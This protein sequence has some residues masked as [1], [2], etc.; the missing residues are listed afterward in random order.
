MYNSESAERV[1]AMLKCRPEIYLVARLSLMSVT[2]TTMSI[3][4]INEM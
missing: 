1:G 4:N 2:I 3:T